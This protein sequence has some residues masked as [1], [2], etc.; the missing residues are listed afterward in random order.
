MSWKAIP[1]VLLTAVVALLVIAFQMRKNH[2]KVLFGSVGYALEQLHRDMTKDSTTNG[3]SSVMLPKIESW[4]TYLKATPKGRLPGFVKP[5]DVFIPASGEYGDTNRPGYLVAVR[6]NDT[7][8]CVLKSDG[9]ST[10]MA[11]TDFEKWP[12]TSLSQ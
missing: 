5:A 12:H 1:L 4:G 6:I 3:T 11:T 10:R 9:K 8:I 2:D 7:L